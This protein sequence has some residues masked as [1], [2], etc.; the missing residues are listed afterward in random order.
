[1]NTVEEDE[2]LVWAWELYQ[3]DLFS[4]GHE[5][6]SRELPRC[7]GVPWIGGGAS[8]GTPTLPIVS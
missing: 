2:A 7:K 3:F 8:V 1:M 4:A 5:E 6:G